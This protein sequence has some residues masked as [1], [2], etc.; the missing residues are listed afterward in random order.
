[1][2][3]AVAVPSWTQSVTRIKRDYLMKFTWTRFFFYLAVVLVILGAQSAIVKASESLGLTTM[4]WW[5]P[6]VLVS[7]GLLVAVVLL[8]REMVSSAS[9][10][11]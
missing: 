9:N 4:S 7:A 8:I 6:L 10:I 1:M 11:R 2:T 5:V 3:L